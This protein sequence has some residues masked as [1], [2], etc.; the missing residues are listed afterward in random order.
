[1]TQTT[2]CTLFWL[3]SYPEAVPPGT[4][5][6]PHTAQALL[7]LLWA[8]ATFEHH[9]ESWSSKR[10]QQTLCKH[11]QHHSQH[12]L[13]NSDIHL[14]VM[15]TSLNLNISQGISELPLVLFPWTIPTSK[16]VRQ[17]SVSHGWKKDQA[18][19]LVPSFTGLRWSWHFEDNEWFLKLPW[20]NTGLYE[21]SCFEGAAH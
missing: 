10:A 18:C 2:A 12:L 1:M 11:L 19:L 14:P 15:Q 13:E 16:E 9:A 21:G 20:Q 8:P 3:M 17:L 6:K 5:T 7:V 4:G